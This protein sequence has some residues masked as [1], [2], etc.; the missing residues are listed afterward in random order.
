MHCSHQRSFR[1][2]EAR[3]IKDLYEETDHWK[4]RNGSIVLKS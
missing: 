4:Y 2:S 3:Q 1:R